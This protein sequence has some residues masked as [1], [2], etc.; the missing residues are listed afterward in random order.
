MKTADRENPNS[1]NR[2]CNKPSPWGGRQEVSSL[3]QPGWKVRKCPAEGEVFFLTFPFIELL[4]HDVPDENSR[5]LLLSGRG[6]DR[7]AN[8][9]VVF[10]HVYGRAEQFRHIEIGR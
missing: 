9:L 7:I 5:S 2:L 4:R 1:R 6:K 8:L 10:G 3:N